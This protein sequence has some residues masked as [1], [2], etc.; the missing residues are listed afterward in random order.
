LWEISFE[1]G[2]DEIGSPSATRGFG[3]CE[4]RT[5]K[6]APQPKQIEPI[7]RDLT[8]V[9]SS[10]IHKA[11][12]TRKTLGDTSDDFGRRRT[13]DQK[14]GGVVPTIRQRTQ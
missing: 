14:T 3:D 12:T 5:G 6:S 11:N 1:K 7:S 10:Q 13:Q 9:E 2:S 8:D 4:E